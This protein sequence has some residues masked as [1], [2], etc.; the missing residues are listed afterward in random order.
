MDNDLTNQVNQ[1]LSANGLISICVSLLCI[2][3]AW[4]ALQNLK[5]EL[6]IRQPKGPQGRLLHLLLAI[7][8]GHAVSG[9]VIDYM[10]WTQ[11]LRHLF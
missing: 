2:A 10:S 7:I 6:I 1:T 3:V 5:L 11:M 4:W 9:F 8:V